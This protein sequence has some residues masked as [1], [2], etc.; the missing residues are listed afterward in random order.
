MVYEEMEKGGVSWCLSNK[1]N[2]VR[3]IGLQKR[4]GDGSPKY[5]ARNV[6]RSNRLVA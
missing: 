6:G 4:H 2:P 3:K 1:H 5:R